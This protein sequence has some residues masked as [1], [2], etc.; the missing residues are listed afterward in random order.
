MLDNSFPFDARQC[1]LPKGGEH[2]GV[3]MGFPQHRGSQAVVHD[4]G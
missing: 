1:L 2:I 4:F 3:G